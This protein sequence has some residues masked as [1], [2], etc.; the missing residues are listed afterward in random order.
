MSN[1]FHKGNP[2]RVWGAYVDMEEI[3]DITLLR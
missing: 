2:R 3:N 1:G